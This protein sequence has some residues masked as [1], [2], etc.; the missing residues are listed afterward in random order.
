[1]R[2]FQG[3]SPVR[4][5][6]L[7]RVGLLAGMLSWAAGPGGAP[8]ASAQVGEGPIF[9]SIDERGIDNIT[10][11]PLVSGLS[12]AVGDPAAGGLS[13]S[14]QFTGAGA[15]QWRHTIMGW[16]R[17]VGSSYTVILGG[18]SE[19]FTL[20]N[21]VFTSDQGSGAT[22]TQSGNTY[23]YTAA[24]GTVATIRQLS[25]GVYG[26]GGLST[27]LDQIVK[28]NG[29][30]LRYH[31]RPA[32]VYRI[33]QDPHPLDPDIIPGPDGLWI[34]Y[35]HEQ[36][37]LQSVTNSLG[38]Q[39][40][41]RY[42]G[43][44]PQFVT[45]YGSDEALWNRVVRVTAINNA[46]DYCAPNASSC[47][48]LTVDWPR[49]DI[50]QPTANAMTL[51]NNLGQAA[52]YTYTN[53]RLTGVRAPGSSLDTMTLAYN[54]QGRV[55]SVTTGSATWTYAYADTAT[56]RTTTVTDPLGNTRRL[57]SSLSTGLP[58]SQ[59]NELNRTTSLLHDTFGRVTRVTYPEG[60]QVRY[61]YDA[62]G[63]VTSVRQV[64]KSGSGLADIVTSA[65]YLSS[66]ANP[67]I[68]N[69]PTSTT[70]AAGE[71]TNY[72][73]NATHGGVVTVTAPAPVAGGVRPQTRY[74]YTSMFA[75][76]RQGGTTPVQAPSAVW[77]LTQTSTCSSGT[78]P[79]CV[80]TANE[81]VTTIGYGST[82]VANN[83][84]PVSTT[85]AAGNGTPTSTTSQGY[86][87][88]GDVI[89]SQP[90]VGGSAARTHY[91]YDAL[92]RPVGVIGP[93]PDGTGPRLRQ[94]ARIIYTPVGQTAA[95]ERGTATAAT[96]AG[97]NAMSVLERQETEYDAAFRPVRARLRGGGA[98]ATILASTEYQYDQA[99]RLLCQ[100]VRMN[101]ASFNLSP[102]SACNL[103]NATGLH[104]SDRIARYVR[105][106]AGQ[107]TEVYNG[108]DMDEA[109]VDMRVGYTAN[110]LQAWVQDG[111]GYRTTYVYDGFDRARDVRYPDPSAT[112]TSSTAD[113]E[114]HTYDAVGRLTTH[115]TR[116]G[117]TITYAYD[118]L[119]RVAARTTPSGQP[120]ISYQY[121][122][123][124]RTTQIS[125]SGHTLAFTYDALGRNLT[126]VT[127]QGTV[128]YQYDAASR[129]TRMTWPDGLYVQYE[130][131]T[132]GGLTR[133]RE[134]G[135]TSGVGVLASYTY[136]NLGRM[137]QIARGNGV[138]TSFGYD[139]ASRL[140]S[141][142][143][144]LA[145]TSH[146]VTAS[147]TR[148]PAGQIASRTLSNEVFAYTGH[149]NVNHTFTVDGLNRYLTGGGASYSYDA[150]G[151]MTGDGTRTYGYDFDNRLTTV[152][153]GGQGAVTLSYDPAGR[154]YQ[155]AQTGG[156]TT[157]FLYD[158]ANLI[159]EY[160]ASNALLR[161]YVHGPGL[162][163][164]LVRYDG[165]STTNRRW[166][167]SDER[168]SVVAETN[169]SG[170][171]VQVNRYD[172]YGQPGAGNTSRFGYTGQMWIAEIGL[173]HYRN[174]V[175]NP[176]LGRF[177]QT[178][179]IGQAGGLNLYA[180]VGNDPI[181]YTDPWGLKKCDPND[182]AGTPCKTPVTGT[183]PPKRGFSCMPGSWPCGG[184]K[185]YSF[186]DFYNPGVDACEYFG[187]CAAE[188][189]EPTCANGVYSEQDISVFRM[190][191]QWVTGSGP[192]DRT[193]G[194]GSVHVNRMMDS[195]RV[196]QAR[197]YFY[198]KYGSS[199]PNDASVTNFAGRFGLGG[200]V[201]AGLDP[202]EQFVGSFRV[203]IFRR[204]NDLEFILTNTSSFRSFAYG[205]APDWDRSRF[206]MAGNMSQTFCWTEPLNQ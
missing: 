63:N 85:V 30:T 135:A 132:V 28:P 22:L 188:E 15:G 87:A 157:R 61:T 18:T 74:A 93:D 144:D 95:V 67:R 16:L 10:G 145:G 62:R 119:G 48:G 170:A 103:R 126:Q 19:T 199:I 153:G 102:P 142:T 181:N 195:Y 73:Y 149:Q 4:F 110:G 203:D 86:N 150:R 186:W 100:A 152:S 99:G 52:R 123:L 43:E 128:S 82:G 77:R 192:A 194:N 205:L 64:A 97:L 88:V 98:A 162:D 191:Y 175:Y 136:D 40:H 118:N 47:E 179:P 159:G 109:Y 39:I 155:T 156:A 91:H 14:I 23:T 198:Q 25:N 131:D 114:R 122:L 35:S 171:A 137:T 54:A 58:V 53:G 50:A 106:A 96:L 60:N 161:R 148:N 200:L 51:T 172:E 111:R 105:N 83:R 78:S 69:Q 36:Y 202:T 201:G 26:H 173:Y 55:S 34:R 174:R 116:S 120:D 80:G 151:N 8:A 138:T 169:A 42:A 193:F 139:A 11:Q 71:V 72:T 3:I 89:W 1:M 9:T 107:V 197:E 101:P 45:G 37:R 81:T 38:Y 5:S 104:G 66:C 7:M 56:Q 165:T 115:R 76:Y 121:D 90:P 129:R 187:N 189:N 59:T 57:V 113:Y 160:S 184:F 164:P 154:L 127:S 178:D 75:F 6:I 31:Y 49:L 168:G 134:N 117:H 84:L 196:N 177:M 108:W 29:E 140:A 176:R 12:I 167:I 79:G 143:Q 92:R 44:F 94:A 13:S 2:S 180:Y 70:D 112:Q 182:N 27:M 183:R 24:D 46:V 190:T 20:A 21:G 32:Q 166:L 206:S 33:E 146:D 68:C 124:G 125:Q 130:Y 133:I 158:G 65:A 204:G 185:D 141:F 147:F 17:R 163:T 41:F